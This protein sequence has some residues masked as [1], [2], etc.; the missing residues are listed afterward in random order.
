MQRIHSTDSRIREASICAN[1]SDHIQSRGR[2]FDADGRQF[3]VGDRHG[4]A[5]SRHTN[6]CDGTMTGYLA[7]YPKTLYSPCENGVPSPFRCNESIPV[8]AISGSSMIHPKNRL[9]KSPPSAGDGT[10]R[11]NSHFRVAPF[12]FRP[13][14]LGRAREN[15]QLCLEWRFQVGDRHVVRPLSRTDSSR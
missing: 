3:Q 9:L 6:M 13:F 2:T 7:G 14:S 1:A 4:V 10:S 8:E 5:G 12:S 15:G 11:S